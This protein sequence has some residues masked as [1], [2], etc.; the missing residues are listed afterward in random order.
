MHETTKRKG[1]SMMSQLTIDGLRGGALF[2]NNQWEATWSCSPSPRIMLANLQKV[3]GLQVT[4]LAAHFHHKEG[5]C[6]T[7]MQILSDTLPNLPP[8]DHALVPADHNSI[9]VPGIDTE[10]I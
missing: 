9:M 4:V 10:T 2:S 3:D 5:L 8:H 6:Y 1:Y 7:Q